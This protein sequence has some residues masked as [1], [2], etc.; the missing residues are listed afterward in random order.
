MLNIILVILLIALFFPAF[1]IYAVGASLGWI[2]KVLLLVILIG[3]ILNIANGRR[4]WW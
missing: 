3:L 4:N 2:L 1:G